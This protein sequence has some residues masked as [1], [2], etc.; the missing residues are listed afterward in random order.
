VIFRFPEVFLQQGYT[1][2]TLPTPE[3]RRK[4][5]LNLSE[6]C[7]VGSSRA[8]YRE[9]LAYELLETALIRCLSMVH[10]HAKPAIDPRLQRAMDL[11]SEN[12]TAPFDSA[13]LAQACG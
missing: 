4:V 6:M 9:M 7:D 2:L 8:A 11:L 3:L 1:R 13:A 5:M 12:L 10:P